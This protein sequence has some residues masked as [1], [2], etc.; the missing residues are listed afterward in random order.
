MD[1]LHKGRVAHIRSYEELDGMYD[2]IVLE[3]SVM[4]NIAPVDALKLLSETERL[5]MLVKEKAPNLSEFIY[6]DKD[7]AYFVDHLDETQKKELPRFLKELESAGQITKEQVK[8]FSP[9]VLP[10]QKESIENVLSILEKAFL[11]LREE[12]VFVWQARDV[13]LYFEDAKFFEKVLA[14][15]NLEFS[16]QEVGGSYNLSI[17][18]LPTLAKELE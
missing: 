1:I 16:E 4:P 10:L 7:L 13:S 18:K 8:R 2:M 12:G 9:H 17:K 5:E 15:P 3:H 6:S 14:N 11:H